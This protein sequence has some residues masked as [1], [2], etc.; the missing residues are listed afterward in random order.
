MQQ[1]QLLSITQILAAPSSKQEAD[2]FVAGSQTRQ[3]RI[4]LT[5]GSTQDQTRIICAGSRGLTV[6]LRGSPVHLR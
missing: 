5:C 2:L 3:E 4:E 1:S 6:V